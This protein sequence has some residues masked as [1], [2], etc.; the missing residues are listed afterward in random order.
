MAKK[1][2][3]SKR[4]RMHESK[5]ME[6]YYEGATGRRTQE[7]EDGGMIHEDRSAI[8]NMPQEVM[9]KTYPRGGSYT[10]ENLDDTITGIDK[11]IGLDDN[12]RN[13]HMVPKKV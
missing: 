9:F 4:D 10:P 8:A 3:Q 7:M 11:Q 12:K 13:S 6:G 2:H 5:G 1:Y